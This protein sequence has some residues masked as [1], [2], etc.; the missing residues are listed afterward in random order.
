MTR[1]G[2]TSAEAAAR[3]AS[4]GPNELAHKKKPGLWLRLLEQ[5]KS[6]MIALL[7]GATVVSA[8]VGDAAEA[9]AIASIVVLNAVVGALQ[10]RR[11]DKAVEAVQKLTAPQTR[12]LRDGQVSVIAARDVV[13]GDVLVLDAGDVV[14]ADATLFE[15]HSVST[16]EAVLTGESE[17][18]SKSTE[19]AP[20]HAPLAEQRHR[21]FMGT[22]LANG[23]GRAEVTHTGART[24]LGKIAQLLD[25]V[26]ESDTPL[27]VQLAKVGRSLLFACLAVVALV[28]GLGVWRAQPWAELL[29]SSI[30][31]AVAVVPEGLP[32]VVTIALAV[33]LQ[34]LARQQVLVRKLPSVETLGSATVIATDKTGTLTTGVMS[35]REVWG[36][37]AA[38]VRLTA[39]SCCDAELRQSDGVG[40]GDSTEVAILRDAAEH[41]I[42]RAAI[43]AENPRV[44]VHPFDSVRKRMSILRRDGRLAVKGAFELL[45]PL[46]SSGLEGAAEAAGA[47]AKRGWRVLAVASGSGPDEAGLELLG[48]IAFADPP[49]PEAIAAIRDAR[50]AGVKV[51]MI[52]GDHPATAEA[53]AREMHLLDDGQSP[54]GMVFARVTPEDKLKIVRRLKAEGEV[55]VMTGDGVND[56]PALKEAHLGIAMGKTAV[57]VTREAADMVLAD[58]N[59]VSIVA[60]IREGR[61]IFDNIQKTLVYL[62]GGNLAELLVVLVA[63]LGGWPAPL[64]PL[65]LLWINLVTDGLPALALVTDPARQSLLERKPRPPASAILGAPEWVRVAIIGVSIFAVTMTVFLLTLREDTVFHSRT[66][67][68]CSLVFSQI[69]VVFSTRDLWKTNFQVGAFTNPRLVAVAVVTALLQVG[70]VSLPWSNALLELGPFSLKILGISL[71]AGLAPVTVIEITKLIR[72]GTR[73][74]PKAHGG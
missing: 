49:R 6:P 61:G 17:P 1:V 30:S 57:E 39:A 23:S 48:L 25:S 72:G 60:A 69:F 3:L 40:V 19:P 29:I 63:A 53:I 26:E 12:V 73:S 38:R 37:D 44:E 2:L 52:T 56:A 55:V 58:D 51:V 74:R 46:C 27:Q 35:V 50:A 24:E 66:M 5:L 9:V 22:S 62:L 31:L 47:M 18:V 54:E 36:A 4:A 21:V 65:H 11:A 8:L 28:A 67:A 15:A 43:E 7:L 34:R 64:L 68:F 70:L 42:T 33:G 59:F 32:A 16:L 71:A 20:H 41:G 10:E 45:A 14:S 13:V